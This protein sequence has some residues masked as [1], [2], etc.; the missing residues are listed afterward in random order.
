MATQ[1]GAFFLKRTDEY[2]LEG[3][4]E[5]EY[6]KRVSDVNRPM[7]AA[8]MVHAWEKSAEYAEGLKEGDSE[9]KRKRF[10]LYKPVVDG[11]KYYEMPKEVWVPV[12][13]GGIENITEA[14]G[15][16]TIG[17]EEPWMIDF[18]KIGEGMQWDSYV[19]G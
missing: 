5:S 1:L 15:T 16:L 12:V 6:E 7:L 18:L 11:F 13:G 8:Y 19:F 14:K 10:E 2:T 3:T 17:V 4:F 9:E